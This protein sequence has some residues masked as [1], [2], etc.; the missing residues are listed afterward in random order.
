MLGSQLKEDIRGISKKEASLSDWKQALLT[1]L[2]R[3]AGK[4]VVRFSRLHLDALLLA[5]VRSPLFHLNTL[6]FVYT[7][8]S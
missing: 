2:S 6:L 8:F 4:P 7:N 1:D 3:V 5:Q